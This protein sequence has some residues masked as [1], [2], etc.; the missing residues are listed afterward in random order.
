MKVL[1]VLLI[2]F[3]IPLFTFSQNFNCTYQS[4]GPNPE[5]P[6]P[7]IAVNL[8]SSP[9][10]SSIVP[11][12]IPSN[13]FGQCCGY[14]S[15]YN[16]L[17]LEVSIHP[18][19]SG[20]SFKVNGANG[21]TYI[22]LNDCNS[23]VYDA[24]HTFC[25]SGPGPY[26]FSFC[27]TGSTD[28]SIT[29]TSIASPEGPENIIT[30]DGCSKQLSVSGLDPNSVTWSSI[31]QNGFESNYYNDYLS[32][33]NGG[34]I[35]TS[36]ILY[37]QNISTV[38]VTPKPNYPPK[39]TFEVCGNPLINATCPGTTLSK[40]CA[41]SFVSIYPT[42]F[43]KAGPDIALCEGGNVTTFGAAVG[44]TAPYT[45]TWTNSLGKIIY[46]IVSQNDTVPI[47][48][49]EI[50]EYSLTIS[51]VSGCPSASDILNVSSFVYIPTANAGNDITTCGASIPTI[52]INA[53]VSQTNSGIW[54][55]GLGT[56][57]TSRTDLNLVYIPS[58]DELNTG[59]ATLILTPT[60]TL[61]CPFNEDTVKIS[62]TKFTSSISAIP[63]NISCNGLKNGSIDLTITPGSP[64]YPIKSILWSTKDTSEDLFNLGVNTY[65]VIV[66]DINDCKDSTSA[67]IS[68][69][70]ILSAP[71]TSLSNIKCFGENTGSLTI[72][73]NGGTPNYSYSIDNETTQTTG[74][75]SNLIA[76]THTITTTDSKLCT[77]NQLISIS[78]PKAPLSLSIIKKNILCNGE[79]SGSIDLTVLGGTSGYTY[80][81]TELNGKFINSNEDLSL[82]KKGLYNVKIR[83]LNGCEIDASIQLIE[84]SKLEG[85]TNVISNYNGQDVSCFNSTDG[86]I[87]VTPKGGTPNYSYLWMDISGNTIS[88][89]QTVYNVGAGT[90]KV[91]I[92]DFNGCKFS[93]DIIVSQPS[94]LISETKILSN[95]SNK[96]VSCEGAFDGE[97]EA[98]AIGGTPNYS[99]SWNTSPIQTSNRLTKLGVGNYIVTISDVNGCQTIDNI[100]LTANPLPKIELPLPINGCNGKNI[101][102]D[103]KNINAEECTWKFSDGKK[104]LNCKPFLTSFENEGCV[105]LELVIKNRQGCT[106]SITSKNFAC[107]LPNP[108]ANFN[109]DEYEISNLKNDVLFSNNST[110]ANTY[111]WDFGDGTVDNSPS[112]IEHK[113]IN[114]DDFNKKTYRVTLY[115]YSENGCF[116]SIVKPITFS[117]QLIYYVPNTFTPDFDEYNNI[118]KP[119]FSS[120]YNSEKYSFMIFNRWGEIIFETTQIED[121]WNGNYHDLKSPDGVYTWKLTITNSFN[122]QKHEDIGHVTL[123]R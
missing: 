2:G 62:L 114:N 111:R 70:L 60:N 101:L 49:S 30:A 75:F 106:A 40:W 77:I 121:G 46:S 109:A 108:V 47:T 64:N 89:N 94:L 118:F 55:G 66:T 50:G 6:S 1:T 81:W 97:I 107:I 29:I 34:Q 33:V 57:K 56:F 93:K 98:N 80:I 69:P 79:N 76:G 105:D 65:S 68:E 90:Y 110:L 14:G 61:G 32:N 112:N 72:E 27:R 43:A 85:F 16:C 39:I 116:D 91:N 95:Y 9:S 115:A 92:T 104:I 15:N 20:I 17:T 48:F 96:G 26:Y 87:T 25:P 78:Q 103:S 5:T 86:K 13:G 99:F 83:D 4:S 28:Y 82:L 10:A 19:S 7:L 31:A 59:I 12:T 63:S 35:G 113:F 45:Y 22:R 73:A 23:T 42:L 11:I 52:Q 74:I 38:S 117:P 51:D 119:I 67:T 37:E 18:N 102:I 100:E 58:I 44:G 84:P 21:N 71:I 36:S 122:S 53:K 54:S 24:G 123:I 41:I 8:S 3:S 88:K 120:G